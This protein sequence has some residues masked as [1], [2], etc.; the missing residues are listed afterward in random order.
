[1]PALTRHA[2]R[3]CLALVCAVG[4]SCVTSLGPTR[5]HAAIERPG[6]IGLVPTADGGGYWIGTSLGDAIPI[7]NAPYLGATPKPLYRPAVGMGRAADGH[8]F[9]LV[10]SDGGI[11]PFGSAGGYGSLGNVRLNAPVVG[12]AGTP[13]GH[14]YWLVASDGGVFPFGS[15]GGYGALGDRHLNQP[16]VGMA[17]TPSGH[18]YWLVAS[19]GG[20]FPF[21]DAPGYGSLGN[22]PLNQPIV[23]MAATPTG[24]GYWLVA[25]D[26]GIFPFGDA[27]GYGSLGSVRLNA[28]IFGMAATANG[29]GY[30]LVAQDGGVFPFGNAPG[31]GSGFGHLK[32]DVAARPECGV[33][34]S[35]VTPGK[36]IIVSLACQELTAYENGVPVIV[37]YIV[38]GRPELATPPGEYSVLSKISPFLMVSPWGFGSPFWYSPGWVQYTLWFRNDGYAI[39]DANWRTNFGPWATEIGSHGCINIPVPIMPSLYAWAPVGTP[40][41]V[42]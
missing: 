23:G 15:A 29:G 31:I 38:T 4:L 32:T 2:S 5:A 30:W 12:M 39:H 41:R 8:G 22:V 19:D 26:G 37:T 7:G 1:V 34:A 36:V 24:H 6:A 33:P 17:A 21:G 28:P 9:W 40:V 35:A 25:S 27:G 10:A 13:D 14:G 18:G 16:V 20:I 11:F 3:L 42:I